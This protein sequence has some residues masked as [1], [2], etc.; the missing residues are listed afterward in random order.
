VPAGL[1]HGQAAKQAFPE[2]ITEQRL[3]KAP[4]GRRHQLNL[5]LCWPLLASSTALQSPDK[6]LKLDIGKGRTER[7]PGPIPTGRLADADLIRPLHLLK[8][9]I[10]I[11]IDGRA[12]HKV[13]V[14]PWFSRRHR[15]QSNVFCQPKRV[16]HRC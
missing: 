1:R 9:Q 10:E 13:P 8:Q 3:V 4:A 11:V 7:L 5:G 16:K 14:L 6:I 15:R 12:F 2:V